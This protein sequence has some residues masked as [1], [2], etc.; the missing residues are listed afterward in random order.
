MLF[1]GL[2]DEW[3]EQELEPEGEPWGAAVLQA[4]G[5]QDADLHGLK[6]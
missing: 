2:S 5:L 1:P 3:N 4:V 6:T